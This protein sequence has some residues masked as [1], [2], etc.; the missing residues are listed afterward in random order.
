MD[1]MQNDPIE[2]ADNLFNYLRD[3]W[4]TVKPVCNSQ[5]QLLDDWFENAL[6]RQREFVNNK[7]GYAYRYY[8]QFLRH[9]D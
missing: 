2:D 5:T 9:R 8:T 6:S 4:R 1:K 3:N 7:D